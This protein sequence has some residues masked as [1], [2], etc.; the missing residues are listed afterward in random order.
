MQELD[1]ITVVIPIYNVEKYLSV[2]LD[3]V[4]N[5]TYSNLEIICINDGSTD[6]SLE[7]CLKYKEKHS[8]IKIIN[9]FNG[10]LSSARNMGIKSSKGSF[11]T[12][13]DS[14]DYVEPTYIEELYNSIKT[15]GTEIS[16]CNRF[17]VTNNS[18]FIHFSNLENNVLSN[19]LTIKSILRGEVMDFSVCDKMFSIRLFKDVLFPENR[20]YEDMFTLVKLIHA[21]NSISCV[22][23]PL[24]NYV[25]RIGSLTKQKYSLKHVDYFYASLQIKNFIFINYPS[26]GPQSDY[27]LI[28][29][30]LFS[31]KVIILSKDKTNSFNLYRSIMLELKKFSFIKLMNLKISFKKRLFLIFFRFTS[32]FII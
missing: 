10:G 26:L 15:N 28:K 14:D 31:L 4:I 17:K 5:Q 7:I 1:L 27:L 19:E 3:S 20:Y 23:K 32:I 13:V 12:F 11:I 24:Y 21:T 6:E 9:K 2:C 29:S 25:F 30:I 16:V 18:K 8:R 22:K